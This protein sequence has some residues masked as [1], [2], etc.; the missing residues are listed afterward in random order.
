MKCLNCQKEIISVRSS[1]KF[2]DAKCKLAYHRKDLSVSKVVPVSVSKDTVNDTVTLSVSKPVTDKKLIFTTESIEE[3]V[4]AYKDLY[5]DSTFVPNWVAN[6]F[7]SKE[8][9]IKNAL[10]SVQKSEGIVKMGLGN[11]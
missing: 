9:A 3:R 5:S 11:D 7:N 6:G 8:E 2:C 1:K 4:K 10:K